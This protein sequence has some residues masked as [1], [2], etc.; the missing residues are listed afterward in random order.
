KVGLFAGRPPKD[1]DH[2][3]QFSKFRILPVS[4]GSKIASNEPPK[5]AKPAA[6][7]QPKRPIHTDVSLAVQARE[8][9]ERAI[10][11][12]EKE[13]TKWI[14]E[15]KCLSCHYS[16]YMLWSFREAGQRG[17]KID[18]EKLAGSTKWSL[19]Q[20]KGH[21]AEG[22]AQTLIGRNRADKN[23][24]TVKLAAAFRDQICKEQ[25]AKGFW[26]AGGQLPGQK[27]PLSETM[28]VSTMICVLGLAMFYYTDEKA[29]E[30]CKKAI[31][32]LKATPPNGDKPALS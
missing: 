29:T 28:Q 7:A 27:R 14:T 20:T 2:H 32:W 9:A 3:V 12:V 30:S 8:T 17:F 19:E 23:E 31:E 11:Y 6:P 5:D 16:G 26:K 10:P 13:G 21:G 18:Q 24:E 1:A 4:V 22:M 15:R 25:D